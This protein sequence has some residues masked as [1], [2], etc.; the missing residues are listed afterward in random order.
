MGSV[1]KEKVIRTGVNTRVIHH[2]ENFSKETGSVMPPIFPTS[3]FV[4]GNEGG[5]D[6]TRSGNPNFRILE[7][8]LSDLEECQFA[9]VFSSGVAAITAI[10]SSLKAGDLI[11]CEENLYGCTV[12]LFEQVFNSFGLKTLWV[13]FTK[14][15]FKE[16]I[17]KHKPALIWIESPTN[18]L[19]KIIDIE[20]I[21]NFSNK[22]QIPVV[23]DN[24]FATPLLQRPLKL[25][26]TLSLTSTTKYIN[27][28]SDAL[29]GAICTE[30][31]AWKEK[32]N[33][34]QKA[35]GL[36]PSPFDCWLINRG[37]K[38]LPLRL[39]RQINN[40][41]KIANQLAE[42]PVIKFV[43]YPFRNDHPQCK[44]AKK[45]MTLGGAIVT[46][47]L[48]TS[49][50][51]T[52]SFCK[53]LRFFKMAESL[54]GIE[55]LVCHPATMTHASVSKETK[56][57]IGITDSLIRLSVGCENIEDLIADLNQALESIS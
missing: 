34:A 38:T 5:F 16:V 31:T 20:A 45:Q 30:S 18:P 47:A 17:A 27:G 23:V 25:G 10:V 6:Y 26:A 21:C 8:V 46:A 9:C 24:T 52:F 1:K 13:D 43:R 28:H 29:G 51:K 35:L 3:T 11:L 40:A 48:N 36:N 50:A 57:K 54:G 14:S 56:L 39:E 55:S 41:S 44:L 42:N 2:K 19:L 32:L 22:M 53:S 7:S 49:Q 33:F 37:I 4:H 15:N 12:R